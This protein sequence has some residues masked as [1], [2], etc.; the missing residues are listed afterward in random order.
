MG[1]FDALFGKKQSKTESVNDTTII[2]ETTF[3][4]L[5]KSENAVSAKILASQSAKLSGIDS[6][7]RL[8]ISQISNLDIKILQKFDDKSTADL[9]SKIMADL[10]KKAKQAIE[11]KTGWGSMGTSKTEN[12]DKTFT[13]ITNK[14][15]K[16]ITS[17]LIN[18]L[19][20]EVASEQG[21]LVENL[22][23]DPYGIGIYD[24]I[25]Q[26]PPVEVIQMMIKAPPCKIDQNLQIRY[27]AEQIGSKIVEIINNDES[28][29]QLATEIDQANKQ[30]NQGIGGAVAEGA[31]GIGEGVGE[32]ARGI[33]EGVGSIMSGGAMPS[34][35]SAVVSCICCVAMLALGMSSGGQKATGNLGAAGAA[36][37]GGMAPRSF[38][39]Y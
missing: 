10:E 4:M 14:V 36:R 5:S 18:K 2:N 34:V 39:R 20:G 17:E 23:L 1:V 29:Q 25:G 6:Y 26:P 31:K 27:V 11:Q 7:C 16:N 37:F 21:L 9:M 35:I 8:E 19:A 32:G 22:K 30:E 12:V 13:K 15:K 38:K 28:A 33:G 24:K 3:N